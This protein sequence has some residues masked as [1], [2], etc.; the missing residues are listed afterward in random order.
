MSR[1][2]QTS[3]GPSLGSDPF[4]QG[5]GTLPYLIRMRERSMRIVAEPALRRPRSEP[6]DEPL[7]APDL[8]PP[9]PELP[10]F[11]DRDESAG[12]L[13]RL[14]GLVLSSG[15]E[16]RLTQLAQTL[17]GRPYDEFGQSPRVTRR[18]LAFFKF[19]YRYWFRVTSSGH[20][21]LPEKEGAILAANHGGLL[22]FDASMIVV[23]GV[24]APKPPRLV[25]TVVDR[26]A[27]TLP[28]VNVF[29]ARVGQVMGS[30]DNVRELL[31]AN[32]LVLIFPEGMAG[33]RKRAAER[34]VLQPFHL[35]F[36]EESL[37]HRVP[38]IPVAV[39]GADD[40]APVLWDLQPLAKLLGLPFFPIT[41]T[42]PLFGLAGLVPYPVR[43]EIAYGEPFR[44][45]DEFPPEALED[46]HAV[47]Y[48]AERVRRRIQEMVD[49]RVLARRS[50]RA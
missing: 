15:E 49:Q 39:I 7:E 33:V 44:F 32:Q 25:R 45:Y 38:I 26:W 50:K 34:Y 20:S 35:G 41:P 31:R 3:L 46:P 16:E 12:A 28:F 42:F 2:E 23:D 36:V 8:G 11:D 4:A 30:R 22:P 47:R 37:R 6:H 27:G 17:R 13:D 29:Y 21:V 43:Y 40:Q 24:L 5:D 10:S 48:M 18:A 14:A 9:V 1:D 19:L